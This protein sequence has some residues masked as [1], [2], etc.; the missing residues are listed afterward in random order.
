VNADVP[1]VG[2][3]LAMRHMVGWSSAEVGYLAAW[4]TLDYLM[5]DYFEV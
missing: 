2:F 4:P 5:L 1:Q 3:S